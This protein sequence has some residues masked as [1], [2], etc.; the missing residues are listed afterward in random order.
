[1]PVDFAVRHCDLRRTGAGVR[2]RLRREEDHRNGVGR[3]GRVG[4]RD[5]R[6]V[7]VPSGTAAKI[8]AILNAGAYPTTVSAP[9][10]GTAG[11]TWYYVPKGTHVAS[12]SKPV[13]VASGTTTVKKAGSAKLKIRLTSAG[14]KM[15]K[16]AKSIALTSKG[17]FTPKS[18]KPVSSKRTFKLK[19]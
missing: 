5:P 9:G 1:V 6:P 19:P 10:P 12:V 8:G 3:V 14:R 13:V 7:A 11:V 4:R 15:L 16:S 2:A 17:T 18:G